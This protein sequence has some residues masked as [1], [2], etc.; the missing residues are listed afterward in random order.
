MWKRSVLTSKL[1]AAGIHLGLSSVAFCAVLYLILA[2][3]YP[4]PWFPIDGGWQG[5]RIMVFVDL[6]LGPTLT[7]VIFNSG[8]TRR[9]LA[10][11]FTVIGVTQ[12]AAFVWGVYAVHG[13]R[14]A[15]ISYYDGAFHS[16][17]ERS[18]RLQDRTLADLAALDPRSPAIVFTEQP[19]TKEAIADMIQRVWYQELAEYEQFDLLRPLQPHLTEI[20]S[21]S[22]EIAQALSGDAKENATVEKLLRS[23]HDLKRED[24]RYV[25]FQGRY[26]DATLVFTTGG[27]VVGSL[28]Y[29]DPKKKSA[30][31]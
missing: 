17:E 25:S 13:Q 7:F 29:I 9:A 16:F 15:A 22:D 24:L 2:R 18:L 10:F 3:W 12:L 21:R 14:P 8:K 1:K 30:E 20:F 27:D 11:D 31:K 6:V 26:E 4:Q 23:R 19:K 28:P 5:V